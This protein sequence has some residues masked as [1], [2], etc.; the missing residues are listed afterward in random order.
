MYSISPTMI[1]ARSTGTIALRAV[2]ENKDKALFPGLFARVRIPLGPPQPMLVIPN[3]A[4]GNDQQGDYVFVV[5]ANDVVARR[6]IVK[7]PLTP[8]AALFA[9][10]LS[11]ADRVVVN[12]IL[13]A[14]PGAKVAPM[15]SSTPAPRRNPDPRRRRHVRQVLHRAPGA[16]ERDRVGHHVARWSSSVSSSGIG[17]STHHAA[18][19]SGDYELSGRERENTRRNRRAADRATGQ[20]R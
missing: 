11:A 17:V 14:R 20:R 19:G 1:S 9:S 8:T 4:I 7:G 16:G 18:D 5:D 12:G 13:N 10:G 15:E 3:S 2:F 6:S